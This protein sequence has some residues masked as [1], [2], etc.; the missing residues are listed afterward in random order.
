MKKIIFSICI[1]IPEILLDET[2]YSR[3]SG[4]N[5]WRVGRAEETKDK[6]AAFKNYLMWTQKAYADEIDADYRMYSYDKEFIDYYVYCK[7][8][9]ENLPMYHIINYYKNHLLQKLSYD[10]DAVFY[11]DIDVIPRTDEDI[12]KV[13]DMNYLYAK[14]N[15]DLAEWGKKMDL[16][17]Y[18][19][20]DRNPAIKYWNCYALLLEEGYHPENDVINTGTVIG[21]SEV[22]QSMDW[23]GE[24]EGLIKKLKDLQEQ[25]VTMF[26]EAIFSRFAFDNETMFSYLVNSKKIK[27]KSLSDE[28][29]GRLPDDEIDPS[30]KMIHAINKKFEL[31]WP[32]VD[33]QG[34]SFT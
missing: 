32:E 9:H 19:S 18:N 30:H 17:K 7:S 2:G 5:P 14:N 3:H 28:W 15:N 1:D 33:Y 31:I 13:H 16:T 34:R 26:P 22:I 29:H 20:C 4:K 25:K 27:Y 23:I 10:Y 6:F 8:V 11:V 12:F 24:F 21:G